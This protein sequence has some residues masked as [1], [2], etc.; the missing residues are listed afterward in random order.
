MSKFLR[1]I[2]YMCIISFSFSSGTAFGKSLSIDPGVI[3]G[4]SL[5][6]CIEISLKNSFEVKLAKLDLLIAETD[7]LYSEAVYDTLIYGN[8]GYSEDKRQELSV[9]SPDDDQTNTYL[10]GISKRLP[11][12]TEISAEWA[13]TRYWAN[14]AF[15]AKNPSHNTELT[16][17][18]R[19]PLGKN[20]FG[21]AD[22]TNVSIT[23]LAVKNADLA[24]KDRIEEQIADTARS[25]ADVLFAKKALDVYEQMLNKA[26][27]LYES[28]KKSYDM[29]IKE[30]VDL[31][32][33]E[34]NLANRR[35][36]V[37]IARNSFQAAQKNLKLLMNI[38]DERRIEP[39]DRLMYIPLDQDLASCMASAFESRRDYKIDKRD[40]EI[41]GLD[42]KVKKNQLW[43]EIDLV[44]T[45]AMNGLEKNFKK[46]AGKSVVRDNTYYY[47]GV[48]VSMPLEDSLA[49][50][51]SRKAKYEKE[52][53]LVSLKETERTIITQVGI[54]YEDTVAYA[55][56]KEF[57][58]KAV[59]L[60]SA[61]LDEEERNF[62][63]GRSSTKRIIDYQQD[64]LLAEL[65]DARITLNHRK[66]KI[67]LYR[68][69]NVILDNYEEVL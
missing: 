49:R 51:E 29:G 9:F 67:D 21:F 56:S 36:D 25:Y 59:E 5:D 34:A 65:E 8:V 24:S 23:K 66:A 54:A 20:F 43:P 22:R 69:M 33:S 11:T 13:D 64:L 52:K 68:T 3:E 40:L 7:I 58:S 44:G 39:K 10:A 12:G 2:T 18:G 62:I 53:A 37:I 27:K 4:I 1:S 63:H 38:E 57:T 28:D 30:K 35:A 47:A 31:L 46:A 42:L 50:S 15:I 55:S 14:S 61:K 41:K 26:E 6:D 19:Q 16:L 17:S 32:A 60:Q 48:E 45:M